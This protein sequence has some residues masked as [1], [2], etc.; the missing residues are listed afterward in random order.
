[1]I[2]I[3]SEPQQN[4]FL[5]LCEF[6]CKRPCPFDDIIIC[7]LLICR[8]DDNPPHVAAADRCSSSSTRPRDQKYQS[9]A[10]AHTDANANAK[11]NAN[12]NAKAKANANAKTAATLDL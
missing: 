11:A 3:T 10:S 9:N 4:L 2:I 8:D 7:N 1:M 5:F 6:F 12:A